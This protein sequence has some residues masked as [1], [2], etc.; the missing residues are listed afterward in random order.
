MV[1]LRSSDLDLDRGTCS[2]GVPAA[3]V[4]PEVDAVV[5]REG[6]LEPGLPATAVEQL[7]LCM[8]PQ[9]VS[10]KDVLCWRTCGAIPNRIEH[11]DR[12]LGRIHRLTDRQPGDRIQHRR[13][14]C[15][16]V[17]RARC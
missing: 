15:P 6:E 9:N 5:D 17:S 11:R 14:L 4:V 3:G 10:I 13:I 2:Y 1:L 12:G 8:R 7:Y 16:R